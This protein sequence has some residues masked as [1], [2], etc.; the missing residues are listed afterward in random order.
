MRH[1]VTTIAAAVILSLGA[2]A[3]ALACRCAPQPLDVYYRN[4]AVVLFARVAGVAKDGPDLRLDLI[5]TDLPYKGEIAK[6]TRFVTA[7]NSAACG[8]AVEPEMQLVVFAEEEAPGSKTLRL[9]TCNGSRRFGPEE[10]ALAEIFP[11]IPPRFLVAQLTS[12][13]G[14][15][16]LAAGLDDAPRPQDPESRGVIGLLDIPAFSHGGFVQ[17]LERRDAEGEGIESGERIESME[18]F[19]AREASYEFPAA[20]VFAAPA[21]WYRL[22]RRGGDFGW[23]R[24][25]DAG[26]FWRYEDLPVDRLSYLTQAWDRFVWPEPGAGIPS[27]IDVGQRREPLEYPVNVREGR[28]IADSLW[29]RVELLDTDGC[30]GGE[31]KVIH[32]GWVHAYGPGGAPAVWFHSRGC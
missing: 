26:T 9:S 12:L 22:R 2:V 17:L 25:A 21:G 18:R 31:P 16:A 27:R 32:A 7:S 11:G 13:Q 10:S 19:E 30:D 28:R 8:L 24:A 4:A 1:P 29:F 14:A 23:L 3:P 20:V 15:A 6:G 5:P